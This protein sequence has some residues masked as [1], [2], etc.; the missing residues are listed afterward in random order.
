MLR[1]NTLLIAFVMHFFSSYAFGDSPYSH[2]IV[3]NWRCSNMRFLERCD[4]QWRAI[5]FIYTSEPD[6]FARITEVITNPWRAVND[7]PCSNAK[8]SVGMKSEFVSSVDIE[9]GRQQV[10]LNIIDDTKPQPT[11]LTLV[12]GPYLGQDG[13]TYTVIQ[14]INIFDGPVG[15]PIYADQ[16]DIGYDN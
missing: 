2:G 4:P 8:Y 9:G 14:S 11:K 13:K 12:A 16:C 15:A 10:T 1:F 6:V 7:P 5:S 3:M